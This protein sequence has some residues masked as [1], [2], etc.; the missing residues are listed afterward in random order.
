MHAITPRADAVLGDVFGCECGAVLADRMAAELHA[1]ENHRCTTCLG[2][3]REELAAGLVRGCSACAGTGRRREQ[4]MWQLAHEEAEQRITVTLVRDVIAGFGG[5]FRLSEAADEVRARLG[6]PVGR[7]P[8]G[9]RVRD[10]LLQLQMWGEIVMV[11]A[12][13]L[14]IDDVPTFLYE[15]P[16][17]QV[18]RTLRPGR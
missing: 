10:L 16:S 6:L 11:S 4:I 7:L 3:A 5:P 17:W 1:A 2:T 14:L 15:D 18:V 9:P 12:P 8:V 13:D